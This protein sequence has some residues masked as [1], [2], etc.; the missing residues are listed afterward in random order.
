MWIPQSEKEIK[1][2]I[3]AG[4]LTETAIF[5]AKA[6]LPGQGR[7]KDIA[8]D[9]AA[10][11]NDGGTLLYGVGEDGHGRPAVSTPI[12][13]KG[14]AERVDQ[15]VRTSIS[16]PPTV[17]VRAV[18]MAGDPGRGYLVVAVP[19][20]PR[21]PHMVV[22]G[23]D[24]RYYGRSA[25]GNVRLSEGEV[26]RL[27]E[28]RQRWEVDQE[29]LLDEAIARA[30]LEP[31]EGYGY[32]HLVA[33]P[34]VPDEE[35]LERAKGDQPVRNVL[36]GLFSKAASPQLFGRSYSPD[37]SEHFSFARVAD[38]WLASHGMSDR[39]PYRDPGN[40]L[41][42]E[43]GLDGG[44]HLF[45][46][47]AADNLD[48]SLVIFEVIVAGLTTRFLAV[49]GELYTAGG[50]LGQVDV[51]VAVTGLSGGVSYIV[52][53][54]MF[55]SPRPYDRDE[56][57]RTGRFSASTLRDDPRSAARRLVYPLVRATTEE[58]YDPFA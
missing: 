41:E 3:E 50:Y 8:V 11:A 32:L 48:N 21:A 53:S 57:R 20:S 27:Y 17:E 4:D 55:S 56:Y 29:A 23:G 47:R 5:D 31:H 24:H 12:D 36:N 10:M 22:V 58:T 13:L 18:P 7:S 26:A 51:G 43:V 34:V 38:G 28:R 2:A 40:V 35:L 14:A 54:R 49:L 19:S 6:T 46:G 30:P 45:C 52:K 1:A 16:E 42:F 37:L 15:I 25:T 39:Q 33:R 44:G 9:V